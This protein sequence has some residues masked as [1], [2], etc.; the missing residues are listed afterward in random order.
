E[1]V[2]CG[3]TTASAPYPANTFYASNAEDTRSG[4]EITKAN[5]FAVSSVSV[6]SQG[7]DICG[8]DLALITLSAV[9]PASVATPLVPRIDRKVTLGEMYTAVGYGQDLPG[10]AGIAGAGARRGRSGL[11]VE[12]APGSCG[13]GV[14]ADEFG[15]NEGICS[16][17]S[18][19][20]ALDADGKVVGVVSRSGDTCNHPVYGSVASWK[21]WII[22]T[23][24]QAA[25]DG[26][27]DPPFWVDSGTSDSASPSSTAN[28]SDAG[29]DGSSGASTGVPEI[30]AA[31]AADL[32]AESGT[33]GDKC[34]ATPDC[35]SGFGCYSP[36]STSD[37]AYCALLCTS[38]TQCTSGT[39]CDAAV[40][41]CIA[42]IAVSSAKSTSC[43]VSS[44][45]HAGGAGNGGLALLAMAAGLLSRKRRLR[46]FAMG[47]KPQSDASRRYTIET[48]PEGWSGG[49][50][51]P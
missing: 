40:G 12:C 49:G 42:P 37:N 28:G 16:G 4:D 5:L 26:K 25:I 33:Q 23:A 24:R 3:V 14:Q 1:T 41:A 6:P 43:A 29:A 31:G 15:G 18:G 32:P 47:L 17:D 36:T 44:V 9:V 35:H 34:A 20:P 11:K 51:N 30:G 10:D 13:S 39:H 45:G 22:A 46:A 38:Q 8:F 2:T 27:Y 50:S 48:I 7:S 21:D 19:G